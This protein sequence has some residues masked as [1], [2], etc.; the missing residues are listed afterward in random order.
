MNLDLNENVDDEGMKREEE[1]TTMSWPLSEVDHMAID[2]RQLSLLN[3]RID[4]EEE[5]YDNEEE[6]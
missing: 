3:S 1:N 5:D 2:P 4:E 6:G